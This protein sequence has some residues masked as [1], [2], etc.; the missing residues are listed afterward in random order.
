MPQIPAPRWFMTRKP[1]LQTRGG[2]AAH[3]IREEEPNAGCLPRQ[4]QGR[5][6]VTLRSGGP[7]FRAPPR[8]SSVMGTSGVASPST[9]VSSCCEAGR[10]TARGSVAVT[11]APESKS[12]A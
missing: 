9:G 12:S 11:T 6:A 2:G 3:Q 7:Y 4:G 5:Q 1:L 8:L 10:G